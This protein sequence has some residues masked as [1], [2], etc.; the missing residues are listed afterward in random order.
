LKILE[1]YYVLKEGLHSKSQ[2]L[3]NLETLK[4]E[5]IEQG[6]KLAFLEAVQQNKS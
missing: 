1:K 4:T 2:L 6:N 3:G 5:F